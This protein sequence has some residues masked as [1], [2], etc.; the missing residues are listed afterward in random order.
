M[1]HFYRGSN[2]M[3]ADI[4][5][6]PLP[7]TSLAS[8]LPLLVPLHCNAVDLQSVSLNTSVPARVWKLQGQLTSCTY[9]SCV[10]LRAKAA[11]AFK[12]RC[13]K[14]ESGLLPAAIG[15]DDVCLRLLR[16]QLFW[17]RMPGST[18][19]WQCQ[20]LHTALGLNMFSSA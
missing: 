15:D 13:K 20:R 17:A 9:V 12:G 4:Y 2:R 7:V 18:D 16:L 19:P 5:Q 14:W 10:Q 1:R 8:S 11:C 3:F 6:V